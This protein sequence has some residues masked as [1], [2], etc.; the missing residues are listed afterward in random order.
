MRIRAELRLRHDVVVRAREAK[1]WT[2]QQLAEAAGIKQR[3]VSFVERMQFRRQRIRDS[4]IKIAAVL[5]LLTDDVLPPDMEEDIMATVVMTRD[6]DTRALLQYNERL[7]SRLSLPAP[8]DMPIDTAELHEK[9]VGMLDTLTPQ[10]QECVV[11]RFGL[12]DGIMH[13]FEDIGKRLGFCRERVNQLV[14]RALRRLGHP[15]RIKVVKA[16]ATPKELESIYGE[17]KQYGEGKSEGE[18]ES[19]GEDG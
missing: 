11:L 2:Q 1:G 18:G 6:I 17:G 9:L 14:Q 19:A 16:Y 13:T 8:D 7:Q 4:A 15:S 5:G 3:D 10:E 12:V